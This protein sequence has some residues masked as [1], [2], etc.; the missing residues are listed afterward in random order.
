MYPQEVWGGESR[1]E[2]LD[3]LSELIGMDGS[4]YNYKYIRVAEKNN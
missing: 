3:N 4:R 1:I 2:S